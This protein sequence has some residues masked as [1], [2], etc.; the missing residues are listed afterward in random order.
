[1]QLL[2]KAWNMNNGMPLETRR[3][4]PLHRAV[5]LDDLPE[6]TRFL[7]EAKYVDEKD[8]NGATPLHGAVSASVVR[9]LVNHGADVEAKDLSGW[10]PLH[11]ACGHGHRDAVYTL[12]SMGV[13][14]NARDATNRTPLH[15]AALHGDKDIVAILLR[16]GA[17]PNALDN[18]GNTPLTWALAN[19]HR[20]AAMEL[21]RCTDGVSSQC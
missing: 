5:A 10:T 19:G 21:A 20:S 15:S 8:E 13:N 2:R 12:L 18:D 7:R 17:D 16:S 11:N 1:M 6:V 14:V 4:Y 3:R 9:A